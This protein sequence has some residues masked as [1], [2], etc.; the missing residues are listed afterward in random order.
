MKNEDRALADAITAKRAEAADAW[1]AFDGA[2]KSAIS[3][4][5]D[6]AKDSESFE[7][8]DSLGKTYSSLK[9]EVSELELRAAK[10]RSWDQPAPGSV[11]P[12]PSD[13]PK[14]VSERF[15]A[16]DVYARMKDSGALDNRDVP[17]GATGAMKALELAELK[18]LLTSSNAGDLV[19]PDRTNILAL[20]PKANL[21]I[22]DAI[23]IGQTTSDS[24]QYEVE[25][26]YTNNAAETAE[27]TAAPESALAY[28][29]VTADVK[30]ITTFI[31]ATKRVLAD[32]GQL[33]TLID[34]RLGYMV[35]ARLQN[36][37]VSGDGTGENLTGLV[38]TSGIAAQALGSDSRADAVHKSITKVRVAGEGMF[39]PTVIGIHPNDAEQLFLE[40]DVNGN[41]LFGGPGG[42]MNRTVWGLVPLVH[43][44]FP[45]GNPVI[46][47]FTQA[48]LW[49]REGLALS[50]S[51][52]HSDYFVKRK[53]AVLAVVRAA[54]GIPEPKAFCELTGF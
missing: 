6:F 28:S 37:V 30:D 16:S 21:S 36:Q 20:T 41:Y 46:G 39:E 8:I 12:V 47:D 40:K 48:I 54:F 2:R 10:M 22:L 9:D 23:T 42:N 38:N 50:M 52:S 34:Q 11:P 5:V 25:T 3:E 19:I 44:A 33:T 27:D 17:F 32:A 31:P 51:D 49:L 35:R 7:K 18:T 29:L 13:A 14:S 26:T 4:G 45:E 53:V 43:I 1:A 24:V 15:M